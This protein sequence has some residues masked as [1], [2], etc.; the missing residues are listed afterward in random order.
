MGTVF[1]FGSSE[2]Y[3]IGLNGLVKS[4]TSVPVKVGVTKPAADWVL[5]GNSGYL[6][7]H[8]YGLRFYNRYLTSD[9][10]KAN[11]AVDSLRFWS[12]SYTGTGAPENWSDLAW[13]VPEK[14]TGAV[15]STL[16]NEYAQ[17]VN[18]TVGVSAAD[19]VGLAGLS[20]EDGAK[21]DLASDAVA[22]VK[23]LYV[24]GVA[25]PRGIYTGT[26]P[27][28]TQVSWL[29]GDGVLRVAGSLDR[30][31][32][33]IVP[34][35]AADGWYEFG[36]ASGWAYGRTTGYSGSPSSTFIYITGT[37]PIWDDY[38]FPAGAKLRL[39]GGILLETVPA[40][41]FSEY[42]MSGLK[43]VYLHGSTAFADGTPLTIPSGCAFR[44]QSGTW[45]PDAVIANRWWLTAKGA[46][47]IT[48]TGDIVNNGTMHISYDGEHAGRNVFRGDVSGNGKFYIY[49][50]GNQ[51]RFQ[52]RFD[53]IDATQQ[54]NFQ[55]GNLIWID[56]LSVGGNFKE[57]TFGGGGTYGMN[58]SWSANGL[59]FGKNDSDATADNELKIG[60][61]NGNASSS[62]DSN[63]KRWR[64]GGHIIVWGNNTVHVG[65]LKSS[66]HVVA[67]REDQHCNQGWLGSAKSKGIG[68]IVIDKL[69]SGEIYGSTNINV[70]VGTVV[71]GSTFDYTYQSNAVNRMTLD[72][73]NSCNASAV[74]KA[75]DIGMLPARISG[76]TGTVTLTDTATKSYT[77]PVDFTQGTDCLYNTAGCIGSGTLGSAPANGTI[78]VTF[79]TT[80]YKP[81]KGQYALARFTSGGDLLENWTVT[82]NKNDQTVK[83]TVVNGMEIRTKKDAT[84]LWL[85]VDK[86]GVTIII[87]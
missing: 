61:L 10:L 37:R 9:E 34:T 28:G 69:T 87:R 32:P 76:F 46:D 5:N 36:L 55:N 8:Y 35:P 26:G 14:A 58:T 64:S 25:V 72:I 84:G 57:L 83:A 77:M 54:D 79:P 44:Y 21:L 43:I 49:N 13:A 1:V 48:Y 86:P 19:R 68:N 52:G 85:K 2:C 60:T 51:G 80:G 41:V 50:F 33:S 3:G 70:K 66:L 23:I 20:L 38:A 74:V 47:E 22:A 7:G 18:A 75:T 62:T 29:E 81:V 30:G 11:A 63:G 4:Q 78:K 82:L 15:P 24:E 31:V 40:G 17:I 27:V 56:T 45:K 6:H 12:F 53:M 73:T 65:E 71:V 59:L 16:T 67:R 39:V 42:D